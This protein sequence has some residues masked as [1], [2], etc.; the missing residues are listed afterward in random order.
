[1]KKDIIK[2]IKISSKKEEKMSISQKKA[3]EM[4]QILLNSNL[5]QL[6]KLVNR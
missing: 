5:S 2:D 3:L 6:N 4:G 1:M